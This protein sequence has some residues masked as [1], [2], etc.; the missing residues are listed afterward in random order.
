MPVNAPG[1]QLLFTVAYG[2]ITTLFRSLPDIT[3]KA[4]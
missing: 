1:R 4:S 2:R 3:P